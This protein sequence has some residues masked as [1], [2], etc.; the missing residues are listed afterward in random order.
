MKI[1]NYDR[2]AP[3][4]ELLSGLSERTFRNS[5]IDALDLKKTDAVLEVGCGTGEGLIRMAE[6]IG[7]RG[8]VTGLD[9]SEGMLAVAAKKLR[10][11]GMDKRVRLV[12]GS[13]LRMPFAKNSFQKVFLSFT[14]E[15]FSDRDMDKLLNEIRRVLSPRGR[16]SVVSLEA[17]T[18]SNLMTKLY[19]FLHRKFP[20]V[21]DCRPVPVRNILEQNGFRVLRHD[22]K[23]LFGLPVGILL[24]GK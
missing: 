6:S 17:R 21:I 9:L 20:S 1:S 14:L 23:S 3:W 4:Y 7:P 22:Q 10:R 24:A 16:L 8:S 18:R 19:V 15:L 2:L 11:K 12:R 13:A 5:G